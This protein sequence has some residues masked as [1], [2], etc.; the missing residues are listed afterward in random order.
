MGKLSAEDARRLV[1]D[2]IIPRHYLATVFERA[3]SASAEDSASQRRLRRIVRRYVTIPG[4][5]DPWNAPADLRLEAT[6]GADA[7][8]LL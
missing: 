2:N 4:H 1:T 7:T 8:R 5:D 3:M 6:V